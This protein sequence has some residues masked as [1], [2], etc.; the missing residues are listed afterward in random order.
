MVVPKLRIAH[1]GRYAE[2]DTDIV[3]SI[4]LSLKQIGHRVQ[5]WNV[6]TH[7]E[8]V[9]NPL[10][11]N[12]GN[13]P[14]YIRL[15]LIRNKLLQFKP[16]LIICNAGGL[17]FT[18]KDKKFLESKGI[19]VLG[20]VLSDPDVFPTIQKIA[21]RYTWLTTNSMLAYRKYKRKGI[22]NVHY[23]PFGIDQ[24]FLKP[25]KVHRK[26]RSD[27]AVI[28]HGR[29]DRMPIAKG[30]SRH[31]KT[32]LFG[33]RWPFSKKISPGPVRGED[34]FKAA[35]SSKMLVNFPR[36][37]KGH[38]NVKI[39]IFEAAATGKLLFTEYFDE[40]S[41]LFRYHKEIVGYRNKNDLIRKIRY[42]L[43]HPEKAKKIGQNAK[44]RV[45]NEH[46]W[47]IKLNKLF[48]ELGIYKLK[49]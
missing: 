29:P 31:F 40:M 13:G 10:K 36:T 47:T 20:I 42:F 8:W 11:R 19:P 39:G 30:L 12:G 6:G 4:F 5:E 45:R 22:N 38:T 25:R 27:V 35:Y 2:G 9:F 15:N 37:F 17:V 41:K 14:I 7:P 24:R 23:F 44:M 18:E 43:K 34:W 46:L 1:F 21:D 28:G 33:K 49:N 26:Y 32:K 3:R 16:D 48:Q